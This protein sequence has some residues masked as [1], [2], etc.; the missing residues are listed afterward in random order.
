MLVG[1]HGNYPRNEKGQTKYP[2]YEFFQQI[3]EVFRCQRPRRA[4]VQRQAPLVEL[5]VGAGDV[6]HVARAGIPVHGRVEP[7]G[8]VADA[9]GRDAARARA[10]ARRCASAT[11]AWTATISTAWRPSSAWWSGGAGGETGVKWVQAYRGD[12]FWKALQRRRLAARADGRGAVPQPHAH[13][14][15]RGLQR[16]L[17]DR[18]R[19]AAAGER[20]GGVPLRARRRLEVHHAPDERPGATTSISPRIEWTTTRPFSTQMYLP[21]PDGRTTLAN[22]FSP[23]VNH[24]E[25]DV[26]DRQADLSGGADAA[27]H[28]PDR[29]RRGE[30]VSQKQ[31]RLETPHL[32]IAYQPT[33]ES[34]FWRT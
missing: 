16:H 24:V 27:D 20:S 32:A 28:R 14:R 25:T 15:A 13:A 29:R 10:S 6:R 33:K 19:H 31:T 26:P 21:M 12:N 22:F 17:P 4:G 7:A 1:E 5:G 9:V 18:G 23:L 2:R 3:V 34:T 11:A 30:P 8:D